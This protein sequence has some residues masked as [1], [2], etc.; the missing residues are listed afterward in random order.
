MVLRKLYARK[1]LQGV[2][3]QVM[4]TFDEEGKNQIEQSLEPPN[5][6]PE[7]LRIK[8]F[9]QQIIANVVRVQTP[10]AALAR[11]LRTPMNNSLSEF[12]FRFTFLFSRKIDTNRY[13]VKIYFD[14]A[15]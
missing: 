7:T 15:M 2:C 5:M 11:E 6:V 10:E 8:G 1:R 14:F 3:I 4:L 9:E 12:N 13:E